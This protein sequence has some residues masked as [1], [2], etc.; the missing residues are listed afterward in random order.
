MNRCNRCHRVLRDPE[1]LKR[2]LGMA[3]FRKLG[4][5]IERRARVSKI[6]GQDWEQMGLFAEEQEEIEI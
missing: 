2:G 5:K 3:C 6:Q 1:S 4:G